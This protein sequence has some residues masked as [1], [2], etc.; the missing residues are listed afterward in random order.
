MTELVF[1]T[2]QRDFC[3]K[4]LNSLSSPNRW[5][6][7]E[8][9][10]EAFS[11]PQ[12]EVLH[13]IE[14]V[15]NDKGDTV[16]LKG[17][18]KPLIALERIKLNPIEE[19]ESFKSVLDFIFPVQ[20]TNT[21]RDVL[22]NMKRNVKTIS[23]YTNTILKGLSGECTGKLTRYTDSIGTVWVENRIPK[24]TALRKVINV[25]KHVR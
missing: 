21:S 13:I 4:S 14:R 1:S 7:T 8:E 18:K 3:Y 22:N 2:Y 5:E 9:A 17:E 12:T 10:R 11:N 15:K 20:G 25:F 6:L 24:E 19:P 23:Q 16:L